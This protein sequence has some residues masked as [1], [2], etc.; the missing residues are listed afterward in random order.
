M[1]P[2]P[3][4]ALD[5]AT[6]ARIAAAA[7]AACPTDADGLPLPIPRGPARPPRLRARKG[8]EATGHPVLPGQLDLFP[9]L[10]QEGER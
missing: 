10:D 2:R 7:L 9:D 4:S 6:A 5:D 8:T 1:I 3:R